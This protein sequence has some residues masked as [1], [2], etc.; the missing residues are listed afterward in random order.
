MEWDDFVARGRPG[1]GGT[2]AY[3][4]GVGCSSKILN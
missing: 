2:S 4:R 3:E 1:G